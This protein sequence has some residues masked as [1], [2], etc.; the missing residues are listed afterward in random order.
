MSPPPVGLAPP[1]GCR[2]T[3]GTR[4]AFAAD[5]LQLTGLLHTVFYV[6]RSKLYS[7][8]LTKIVLFVSNSI[9]SL[10][11]DDKFMKINSA[12]CRI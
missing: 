8:N 12:D 4:A 11:Y 5:C 10:L 9:Y 7:L 3:W 6:D 2:S 1:A